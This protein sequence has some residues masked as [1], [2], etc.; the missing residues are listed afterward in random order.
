MCNKA[1]DTYPSTIKFVLECFITQES[2]IKWLIYI[3]F[4]FDFIPDRYETQGMCD[5]VV[6]EDPFFNCI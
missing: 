4:I 1:V 5:R 6:S 3:F 2:V